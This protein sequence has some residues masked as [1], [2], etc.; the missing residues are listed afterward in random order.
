MTAS[1]SSY[2]DPRGRRRAQLR[3]G[4]A[5][6]PLRCRA[7]YPELVVQ[8]WVGFLIKSETPY[9]IIVRLNEAIKKRA[10]EAERARG[11]GEDRSGARGRLTGGV[12]SPCQAQIAHSGKDVKD[13][14]IKMRE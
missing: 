13:S 5:G 1:P 10:H 14:G 3:T 2:E 6:C 7:G 8:D 12:R 9:E 4:F 11:A